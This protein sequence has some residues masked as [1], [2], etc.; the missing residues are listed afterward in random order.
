MR[1]VSILHPRN[2]ANGVDLSFNESGE[3]LVLKRQGEAVLI[4]LPSSFVVRLFSFSLLKRLG[5][6][7]CLRL[8]GFGRDLS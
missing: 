6:T 4:E 2:G 8:T 3:V 1:V 7:E 5:Y